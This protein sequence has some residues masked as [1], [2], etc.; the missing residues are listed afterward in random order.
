MFAHINE[1]VA[2]NMVWP[3]GPSTG[4]TC[5]MHLTEMFT[6]FRQK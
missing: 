5:S 2:Y 4:K 3:Q 6:H 1:E